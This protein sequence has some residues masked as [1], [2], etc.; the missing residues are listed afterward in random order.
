MIE[1]LKDLQA[2]LK[3]LR[4]QGVTEMQFGNLSLK[5][6]DL[7]KDDYRTESSDSAIP[8]PLLGFQQGELT[9]EQLMF[10]SANPEGN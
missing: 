4:K 9:D 1:N 3:L 2:L 6:G 5:L 7:P 10:Y 8:D